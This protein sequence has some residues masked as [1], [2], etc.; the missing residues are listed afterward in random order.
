[1]NQLMKTLVGRPN[2]CRRRSSLEPASFCCARGSEEVDEVDLRR[3]RG[4]WVE[5]R[6]SFDE[7]ESGGMGGGVGEVGGEVVGE[8][9]GRG[10]VYERE[11]G[12]K[13]VKQEQKRTL[14][15]LR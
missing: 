3:E 15:L 11:K 1:M 8:V 2:R 13:A 10:S 5:D 7:G 9:G 6:G 12:R 4:R 14:T